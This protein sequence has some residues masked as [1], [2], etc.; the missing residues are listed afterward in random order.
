MQLNRTIRRLLYILTGLCLALLLTLAGEPTNLWVLRPAAVMAEVPSS[1]VQAL[2][3]EGREAF[4]RGALTAA[5]TTL[6]TALGTARSQNDTLGEVMVQSNL[7]L[8]YGQLGE[9]PSAE[10]AI[11]TSL[12]LLDSPGS[13]GEN[14]QRVRAQ[15]LNVQGRLQLGQ[16]NAE[17]AFESWQ[18][19]AA[20]YQGVGDRRGN[21]RSRIRQAKALQALAFHRRAVDEILLPLRQELAAEPA[22]PVKAT[23]LRNL[24]EAL[25][26]A[27]SLQ[28]ARHVAQESL[29]VAEHLQLP[30]E[31]VA[32]QLTLGNIEYAQAKEYETQNNTD[33]IRGAVEDALVWYRQVSATGDS[34]NGVRSQLNQLKLLV[35]FDEMDAAVALWSEL[36]NQPDTLLPNQDGI[37]ARI[38]LANSLERLAQQQVPGGPSWAQIIAILQT[39]QAD[40]AQL[41]DTRAAAHV[42]GYLGKVYKSK[43]ERENNWTDLQTAQQ[44]TEEALFLAKTVNAADISY[45]WYEQLGD[46]HLRLGEAGQEADYK[47]AAIAAYR[48]AVNSLKVLRSDLTQI[49]PEIRFS[50]QNVIEPL[51]RK[52]ISL[53]LDEDDSPSQANLNDATT[54]L[55]SLQLQEI[56]NFLRADCL[57]GIEKSVDE[58]ADEIAGNQRVAVLYPVILPDRLGIIAKFPA[59]TSQTQQATSTGAL[60]YYQSPIN[61]DD[62]KDAITK[63]RRQL[64]ASDF[65]VQ[66]TGQQIYGWLFPERLQQDLVSHAPETLVFIPDGILRNI[67]IAALYDGDAY[68]AESYSVAVVPPGLRLDAKSFKEKSFTALTFGLTESRGGLPPLPN[69]ATEIERIEQQIPAQTFLDNRFTR[70][71]FAQ[72]L[73]QSSAP[74]IHL[75]THGEFSS[76]LDKTFIQAWDDRI[77]INDL[78]Q[79]LQ[80]DR[81]EPI[82]LLVLSA[83]ETATGDQRA[84]LGLAGMAIRA[85]ARST[86][87]S[88]WQVDDIA[89]SIF[90]TQFYEAL[91]TGSAS[92]ADALRTAQTHLIED[93]NFRHPYYWAPFVLIGNWL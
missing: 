69:V 20:V 18:Q 3:T 12:Q 23:S 47:P 72:I 86:I 22:S 77:S 21:I 35:E 34:A 2:L 81:S 27:N 36:K 31:V 62:L 17:A 14:W 16:G 32:T 19:A 8:V 41:Q 44:L 74:F 55:E 39:A 82:E 43:G 90:M 83:C 67:P 64:K 7:A 13:E 66:K 26:V 85:G 87:A 9:W 79:W 88:L 48:G 80:R 53:L 71:N 42:L 46:L 92:K 93:R 73:Q 29:A 70:S 84:V 76:Q 10:T 78:S 65:N 56:E 24:A 75:A 68:L 37:Y 33:Q 25:A 49:N 30:D 59:G 38:N 91:A 57:A 15:T 51:H 52:F 4:E 1:Q 50:F 5:A 11:A 54:V 6:E 61:P 60:R 28:Q 89:T 58:I 63:M 45:L 40:A